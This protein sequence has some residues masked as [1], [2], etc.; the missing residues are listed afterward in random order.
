MM[1]HPGMVNQGGKVFNFTG[2]YAMRGVYIYKLSGGTC[3]LST[4]LEGH[5]REDWDVIVTPSPF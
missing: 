4:D 2:L 5:G 3:S 1:R